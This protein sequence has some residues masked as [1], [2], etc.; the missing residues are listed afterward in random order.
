MIIT[1][2]HLGYIKRTPLSEYKSQNRGGVGSKGSD[3]R[4]EDFIEYI[5]PASMHSYMLFF[6]QKDVAIGL[7]CTKYPKDLRIQRVVLYKTCLILR[8]RQSQCI[9]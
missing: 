8:R 2:S 5:Y 4:D 7:K 9:Y 6:T 3:S 1:I